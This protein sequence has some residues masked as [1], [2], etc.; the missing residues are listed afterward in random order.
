MINYTKEGQP[1]WVLLQMK[2]LRDETGAVRYVL[3][4]V[5]H[6]VWAG[7]C[8]SCVIKQLNLSSQTSDLSWLL[9]DTLDV[10][11]GHDSDVV[12]E[13]REA[14]QSSQSAASTRI[15]NSI[16][17][18][19]QRLQDASALAFEATSGRHSGPGHAMKRKPTFEVVKAPTSACAPLGVLGATSS[20]QPREVITDP[21]QLQD[22]EAVMQ[23]Q[24]QVSSHFDI[25]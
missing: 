21:T 19:N 2:N 16:R 15:E 17:D 8:C 3:G 1:F 24:N 12:R 13:Q 20:K 7:H 10:T 9:N 23:W 22:P 14:L 11:Q 18:R 5:S 6:L 25:N 4:H